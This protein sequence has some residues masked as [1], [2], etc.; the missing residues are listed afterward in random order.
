MAR[1]LSQINKAILPSGFE[2]VKGEG[3]F[4]FWPLADSLDKETPDSIYTTSVA[5]ISVSYAL[6]AVSQA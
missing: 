2:L 4:Y 3:Y 1:S 5:D 6:W